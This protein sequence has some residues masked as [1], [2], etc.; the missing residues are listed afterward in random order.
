MGDMVWSSRETTISDKGVIV[1]VDIDGV[2]F[3]CSFDT[4]DV[5]SVNGTKVNFTAM[6]HITEISVNT[7]PRW[8]R[9]LNWIV[10]R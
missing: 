9:W 2:A 4:F 8:K 10:R 1:E 5:V 3:K 6:G 7:L